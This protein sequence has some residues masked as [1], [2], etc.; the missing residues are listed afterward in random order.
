MGALSRPG[1]FDRR[2]DADPLAGRD[3][4][5]HVLLPRRAV[6]I[7]RQ[8]ATGLI[9]QKRVDSDYVVTLKMVEDDLVGDGEERPVGTPAAL[10]AGL[11]ANSAHPFV[12]TNGGIAFPAGLRFFPQSREDVLP[13][14]E[15][16]PEKS[17]LLGGGGR[18]LERVGQT[19]G[20]N[21]HRESGSGE[22]L[23]K[24]SLEFL[25]PCERLRP[26][27]LDP[28][29]LGFFLS[30]LMVDGFGIRHGSPGVIP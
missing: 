3:E 26:F 16:A 19:V 4:R 17:D 7:R 29:Q 14:P 15:E 6:E 5:R 28:G 11:L 23:G 2:R 27:L 10:H 24:P 22:I 13:A 25:E 30:D 8:E 9:G 18:D 12:G 21:W 20:W 1:P